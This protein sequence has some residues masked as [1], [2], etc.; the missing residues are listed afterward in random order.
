MAKNKPE[1]VGLRISHK[2]M[3]HYWACWGQWWRWRS[4][5]RQIWGRRA[6]PWRPRSRVLCT[7]D[8]QQPW[9]RVLE[10]AWRRIWRHRARLS[11]EKKQISCPRCRWPPPSTPRSPGHGVLR[12]VVGL[13]ASCHGPWRRIGGGE[14]TRR[15]TIGGWE[16]RE[17]NNRSAAVT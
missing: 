11:L 6:W 15:G 9:L 10:V 1:K 5:E 8:A 13:V 16:R 12:E 4:P 2:K 17:R 3:A 7:G 14:E